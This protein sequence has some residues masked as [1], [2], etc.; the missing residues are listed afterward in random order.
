MG[1]EEWWAVSG[2]VEA[3]GGEWLDGGGGRA[4]VAQRPDLI[5]K[6]GRLVVAWPGWRGTRLLL[7]WSG[8]SGGFGG[9]G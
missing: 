1:G 2:W 4:M 7:L 8:L 6:V 5:E 3:V 9:L